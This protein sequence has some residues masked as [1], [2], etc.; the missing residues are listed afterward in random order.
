[1]AQ[2]L[3]G[4]SD[5]NLAEIKVQDFIGGLNTMNGPLVLA[6]NE[7]PDAQNCFGVPGRL[8]YC[9]G[10]IQSCTQPHPADA[11]AE[12][13]DV[14]QI[15]HEVMWGGGNM[16]DVTGSTAVLIKSGAYTTGQQ[17][18]HQDLGGILYYTTKTVPLR[19][20]DGTTEMATPNGGG[21]G[22]VPPPS[23]TALAAFA[24][25]L[26]MGN[27]TIVSG[28][29]TYYPGGFIYCNVNDPT[30]W[31]GAN[32]NQLGSNEFI[33]W[34]IPLGVSAAGVP[35]TGSIMFGCMNQ[36]FVYSGPLN[37]L[38]QHIVNSPVGAF[39]PN[40]AVFI[41]SEDLFPGVVFIGSDTQFWRTNGII[42]EC[43][44]KKI[45]NDVYSV[46]QN[47]IQMSATQRF[48]GAYNNQWHYYICDM[49]NNE[50][51]AYRWSD[52]S[53][54]AFNG[55]P[56]GALIT[57][58]DPTGFTVVYS[59]SN[60]ATVPV[61]FYELG[62]AQTNFNGS[63]PVIYYTT[64]YL[65][66]NA[67][68][69]EKD[70]FWVT[71][72]TLNNFDTYQ[73]QATTLPRSDN[74]VLVSQP[75][76]MNNP[77]SSGESSGDLIWDVGNWDEANWAGFPSLGNQ[78]AINSGMFSVAVPASEWIPYATTQPLRSGAITI[79]ISWVP[80]NLTPAMDITAIETRFNPRGRK[81]VGG[82]LYQAQSGVTQNGVDPFVGTVPS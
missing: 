5:D 23:G 51:F 80:N 42:T 26:I 34:I 54:W 24:G 40:S 68:G 81:T 29:T 22:I 64:P 6:S 12:F 48:F 14:N 15:R 53:W 37:N 44:S 9:G 76:M 56:S 7:T 55:W 78:P 49:G 57:G 11:A 8:I 35:P 61:A 28:G 41:P 17:V 75:L 59:A 10:Y 16:Y 36:I 13:Y 82:Q 72:D 63:P 45:Q 30:R 73:I 47:A 39:D 4:T 46:V 77:T 52:R 71:L 25:S 2:K 60:S 31:N 27:P 21:T 18:A 20:W 33:Q 62:L 32:L 43:V 67:P 69:L 3:R 66:G 50:Q 19:Q 70:W 1:M 74:S 65:H 38:T 79:K 58:H